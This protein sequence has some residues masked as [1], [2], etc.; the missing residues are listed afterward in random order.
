[1]STVTTSMFTFPL[2]DDAAL[3]PRT[4]A[5]T[6]A[7]HEVFTANFERIT[8]WNPS[9]EGRPTPEDTRRNLAEAG[10]AWVDG[11]RLPL[12]VGVKAEGGW[13]LVGAVGLE[14]NGTAGTGEAGYWLDASAEGRG[15]ATRA[16][17]ALLD[18]AFGPV[19]LHRVELRIAPTNEPSR[20]V[21]RRLGFTE[22]GVLREALAFPGG[23]QDELVYGLLAEEWPTA[24]G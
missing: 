5:I 8:R 7:Y 24:R 6:A 4:P 10:R 14:I 2:G 9:I 19:G 11:T 1:M 20:K 12:A 21:A 13:R 3:I 17:S 15:L 22:E 23:R 18:E 16:M